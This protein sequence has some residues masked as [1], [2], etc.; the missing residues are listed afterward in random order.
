MRS[1][2]RA[3]NDPALVEAGSKAR[4]A[5]HGALEER[6]FG[7]AF[8]AREQ[9]QAGL[10]DAQQRLTK[11][12]GSAAP[13]FRDPMSEWPMPPDPWAPPATG[14]AED[15]VELAMAL[16][17]RREGADGAVATPPVGAATGSA[18]PPPT[19]FS[20]PVNPPN[21]LDLPDPKDVV[22]DDI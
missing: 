18:V 4:A 3:L 20:T 12:R 16:P 7:S 21:P 6:A 13:I 10:D 9:L 11:F 1:F 19:P 22:L 5:A 15:N 2:L 8:R 14:D 17:H